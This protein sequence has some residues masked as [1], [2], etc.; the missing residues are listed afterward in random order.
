VDIDLRQKPCMQIQNLHRVLNI[1]TNLTAMCMR[2]RDRPGG[3]SPIELQ[4]HERPCM[5]AGCCMIDRVYIYI[6][7][8]YRIAYALHAC[9]RFIIRDGI[10]IYIYIYICASG[11]PPPAA[12]PAIYI[13]IYIICVCIH[14]Y[15]HARLHRCMHACM[16]AC[17]PTV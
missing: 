10:H 1:Y 16:H 6:Y 12:R 5:H 17:M 4:D 7:T 2:S 8:H 9:M 14:T 15:V 11:R 13:Y 3:G